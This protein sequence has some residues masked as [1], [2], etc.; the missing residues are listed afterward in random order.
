MGCLTVRFGSSI[1]HGRVSTLA[2]SLFL[3]AGTAAAQDIS[4][5][6]DPAEGLTGNY[7]GGESPAQAI[8]NIATTKYLSFD[9]PGSGIDLQPSGTGAVRALGIMTANDDAGRDPTS[10]ILIG[11][12]DGI[13]GI[14]IASGLLFPSVDRYTF[15]QATF[16]NNIAYPYYRVIFP[17]LRSSDRMQVAEIQLLEQPSVVLGGAAIVNV[18]YP[19]GASS[20]GNEG[21]AQLFDG[22][23]NTKCGVFA[24][25][26]GP[27]TI[28]FV[29]A[30]GS[31]IAA[32]FPSSAATTMW[33]F[34]GAPPRTS[35]CRDQTMV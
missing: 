28:D 3:L 20:P 10:F 21:P 16:S 30:A 26:F 6:G 33:R 27:T 24:G 9:G 35:S 29:P 15:A 23:C 14:E 31:T 8:D 11:S 25:S 22:N 7:P 5:P 19:D 32:A 4:R 2:L 1:S 13:N 12:N 18:V 34:R 17:T